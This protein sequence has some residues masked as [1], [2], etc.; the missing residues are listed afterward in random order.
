MKYAR[1][2]EDVKR[3]VTS[4]TVQIYEVYSPL[5]L[6]NIAHFLEKR[7]NLNFVRADVLRC[8]LQAMGDKNWL[9]EGGLEIA[10]KHLGIR[11]GS[12]ERHNTLALQCAEHSRQFFQRLG[13]ASILLGILFVISFLYHIGPSLPFFSH[14]SFSSISLIFNGMLL[15]LALGNFSKTFDIE[16]HFRIQERLP[17]PG[18]IGY[19]ILC[20]LGIFGF[21]YIY[22]Q[23]PI[24]LYVESVGL[25]CWWL[26]LADYLTERRR[27]N[28]LATLDADGFDDPGLISENA[29][30]AERDP[31]GPLQINYSL[32]RQGT[33]FC[34]WLG[35]L[36][37]LW[38]WQYPTIFAA[39]PAWGQPYLPDIGAWSSFGLGWWIALGV[40]MVGCVTPNIGLLSAI[41]TE[42]I[43]HR[44]LQYNMRLPSDCH[45]PLLFKMRLIC[46][47]RHR[48]FTTANTQV[49]DYAGLADV[50]SLDAL[51]WA[52]AIAASTSVSESELEPQGEDRD[53]MKALEQAVKRER[54]P[55]RVLEPWDYLPGLAFIA[56]NEDEG[57]MLARGSYLEQLGISLDAVKHPR[58]MHQQEGK[59]VLYLARGGRWEPYSE[60]LRH[61][62][63]MV[64]FGYVTFRHEI[65][66]DAIPAFRVLKRLQVETRLL[67]PDDPERAKILA[68]QV[69]VLMHQGKQLPEELERSMKQFER[70]TVGAMGLVI[71]AQEQPQVKVPTDITILVED[72]E[73]TPNPDQP[74]VRP[75][76]HN[77]ELP[78]HIT[79]G[80]IEQ[81]IPTLLLIRT[82]QYAALRGLFL[83]L[84]CCLGGIGV[85]F[86]GILHPV[87]VLG[88]T[89]LAE[90]LLF[91]HTRHVERFDPDR[92]L[93]DLMSL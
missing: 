83:F 15:F 38:W 78:V 65:R 9:E 56:H 52:R 81:L 32:T 77:A 88:W 70:N 37:G 76:T 1:K 44:A 63:R 10:L 11:S 34:A 43:Q 80:G 55:M 6:W 50:S 39:L 24:P 4:R 29:V 72:D 28:L 60:E 92:S 73:D 3:P 17:I 49:S 84:F 45:I 16:I 31:L 7:N 79:R 21:Y 5:A 62:H 85:A 47:F 40:W 87:L 8:Q 57:F 58:Y 91:L 69:G 67:S 12:P 18:T 82:G 13:T 30:L 25:L 74:R 86:L 20:L 53:F 41:I 46:F 66:K 22:W 27:Y 36:A 93:E 19:L 35:L 54:A 51:S 61:I 89:L 71:H 42:M 26:V 64:V 68:Q 48:M 59:T 14:T 75:D 33:T 90:G 2:E 23:H